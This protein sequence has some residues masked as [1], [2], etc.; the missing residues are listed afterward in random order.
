MYKTLLYKLVTYLSPNFDKYIADKFSGSEYLNIVDIGFYKGSF[1]R[2][3]VSKVVKLNKDI[4]IKVYSFDPNEKTILS[5]F[6]KFHDTNNF[7]WHHSN[8]AIGEFAKKENFTILKAFPSSGSS[9]VNILEDSFWYKS[10]KLI[11]DPFGKKDLHTSTISVEVDTLDNLF[12]KVQNINLLKI[13]V[14][15][16]S[17]QVLKG[18]KEFLLNNS[19]ILQVEVLS[20]KTE[21]DIRESEIIDFLN[22][23]EYSLTSKKKHYT[24]HLFSDVICVDYL[25]EK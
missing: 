9:I 7:E 2:N 20:K 15:G 25:F 5:E 22:S 21:F 24:T 14:E 18:A 19:P 6:K 3:I 1:T 13:D 8:K 23:V 16:F 11:I 10:R 4:L 17:F 12:N